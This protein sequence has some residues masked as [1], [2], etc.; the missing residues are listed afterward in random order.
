M[1]ADRLLTILLLLQ[2][3][4]R[5]TARELAARLE[6]SERTVYRDMEALSIAGVPVFAERG[7]NGGWSLVDGYE[8]HLTGLSATE[9]QALFATRPDRLLADLGLHEASEAALVKLLAA[10]PSV[11]RRDAEHARQ[12]LHVDAAGWGRTDEDVSALPALQEAVWEERRVRFLYLRPEAEP[13]ARVA[14]P[15]GLVAKGSAW[16]LVAAVDGEPR[17]YRVSR[18]RDVVV[19]DEPARRP[20]GFDLGAYWSRSTGE[21]RAKL[22]RYTATARV[23][24]GVLTWMTWVARYAR[25]EGAGEPDADGWVELEL[26]FQV[27]EEAV[28]FGLTFGARVELLEPAGLREK[29]RTLAA[30]TVAL[31][32]RNRE[33]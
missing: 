17:T 16:Y 1:R 19:G 9:I 11:S 6:V 2:T 30:E 7:A 8:T 33:R 13:A 24:P 32:A 26:A 21:F 14:D 15:L 31:Y 25:I 27:E 22:P 18:V 28:T 4:G 29:V 12:R 10:L 3:H 23:A 20:E 5:M